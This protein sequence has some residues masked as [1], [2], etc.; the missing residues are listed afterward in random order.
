M[1]VRE[2][3]KKALARVAGSDWILAG[4]NGEAIGYVAGSVVRPVSGGGCYRGPS[5]AACGSRGDPVSS[6]LALPLR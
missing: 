2:Q 4:R 3:L 1:N 5:A 6:A